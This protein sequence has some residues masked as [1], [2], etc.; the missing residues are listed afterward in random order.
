MALNLKQDK[1][2][3]GFDIQTKDSICNIKLTQYADDTCL[4]LRDQDDIKHALRNINIFSQISGLKLN[5]TKTEGLSLGRNFQMK[6]NSDGI[7]WPDEPIRYLGI[8][9]GHDAK[10]CS[11]LNWENKIDK[12]QKLIDS[13]RTR[14][15][16]LQG[17]I[18]I[19]KSLLIP[20][21]TYSASLLPIPNNL[22]KEA[23]K[24][25]FKFI[26]GNTER[27]QR[28]V[29]INTYEN[30]GLKMTDLESHF[31]ALKASW[32]SRI[33]DNSYSQWKCLPQHF[34][35]TV[36][37]TYLNKMSF[38]KLE[39]MPVLKSIPE[40]YAEVIIGF[41]K[42]RPHVTIQNKMD[43]FGQFIWGN[44]LLT[45]NGRCLFSTSF[46]KSNILY[47]TDVLEPCGKLKQNIYQNL[48]DKRHYLR[49]MSLIKDVL[50]PYKQYRFSDDGIPTIKH[51]V[52]PDCSKKRSK[53][54]YGEII[55]KKS[56]AI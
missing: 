39:Q 37:K 3:H 42:S 51:E 6:Q 20:K 25:I 15:L 36:T 49:I 17:K 16:T 22:V 41:C 12:I 31:M 35:E 33:Y 32:I 43:L 44:R 2:V 7:K 5:L 1:S 27:I 40:F 4:F 13:W 8:F 48:N 56:S 45:V 30:G 50:K 55:K 21:I 24:M 34:I 14:H 29:L 9:I 47:I 52:F 26:W 10:I 19:A 11:T 18:L 38:E 46:I 54:F 28:R 23:N 53:Y